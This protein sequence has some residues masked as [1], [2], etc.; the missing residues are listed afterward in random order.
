MKKFC[1][2]HQ[3]SYS[4]FKGY[5]YRICKASKIFTTNKVK[6]NMRVVKDGVSKFIPL[7]IDNGGLLNTCK[8]SNEKA[9]I[10]IELNSGN[11]IILPLE[12]SDSNL[13]WLIKILDAPC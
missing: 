13:L 12:V 9:E 4:I 1:R 11:K 5:R 10:K 2:T 7:Q 3:L 8:I 6:D